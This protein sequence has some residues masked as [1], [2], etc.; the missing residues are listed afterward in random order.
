MLGASCVLLD[1]EDPVWPALRRISG[2]GIA[3]HSAKHT[4]DSFEVNVANAP[5]LYRRAKTTMLN[6]L[7]RPIVGPQTKPSNSAATH[8]AVRLDPNLGR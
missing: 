3:E 7:V 4:L 8:P 6:D 2:L 5:L 1:C